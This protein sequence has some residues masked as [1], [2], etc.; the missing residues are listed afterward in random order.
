MV[1][2]NV[3]P[4]ITSEPVTEAVLGGQYHYDVDAA[5]LGEREVLSYQ[6][7][8]AP[9]GMSIN[10]VTGV[11]SWQPTATG[12]Y[13]VRVRVVDSSGNGHEQVFAVEVSPDSAAPTIDL[14][15][16]QHTIEPGG[17]LLVT[18]LADDEVSVTVS[19]QRPAFLTRPH[20]WPGG[21]RLR[22]DQEHS[23]S[24][25]V[26]GEPRLDVAALRGERPVSG[27]EFEDAVLGVA[28]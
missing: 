22:I 24:E 1:E 15:V 6:L 4:R 21:G 13:P 2:S 11:I 14:N 10:L 3:T 16:G 23:R 17:S 26:G 5:D 7:L 27:R 18:A 20:E 28:W 25:V 12:S 8:Q 19:V 9:S